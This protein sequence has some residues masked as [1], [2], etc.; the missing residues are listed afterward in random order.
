MAHNFPLPPLPAFG[1]FIVDKARLIKSIVNSCA[2]D[3]SRALIIVVR[4]KG[5]IAFRSSTKNRV[6][7]WKVIFCWNLAYAHNV[8]N[9]SFSIMPF[10]EM[11]RNLKQGACGGC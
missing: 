6:M 8:A 5:D 10:S 3:V 2:M 9:G 1:C 7:V 4:A 11:S